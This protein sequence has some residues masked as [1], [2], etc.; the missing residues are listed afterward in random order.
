M[1]C[2]SIVYLL[3]AF[4]N[5]TLIS[6]VLI[7][8]LNLSIDVSSFVGLL[9]HLKLRLQLLSCLDLLEQWWTTVWWLVAN[10]ANALL[11]LLEE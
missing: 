5:G 1:D 4:L 3:T 6:K 10:L 11:L 2:L 9:H 7:C 8:H